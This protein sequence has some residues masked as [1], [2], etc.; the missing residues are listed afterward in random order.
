MTTSQILLILLAGL[1]YYNSTNTYEYAKYI[2]EADVLPIE[3][4]SS[5]A[6]RALAPQASLMTTDNIK[7]IL[8]ASYKLKNAM[9]EIGTIRLGEGENTAGS[10]ALFDILESVEPH[11]DKSASERVHTMRHSVNRIHDTKKNIERF[12][13]MQERMKASND[14]A[15]KADILLDVLAPIVGFDQINTLRGMTSMLSSLND[16][17][18]KLPEFSAAEEEKS[19]A[20]AD[21]EMGFTDFGATEES[22]SRDEKEQKK[23][24]AEIIEMFD[25]NKKDL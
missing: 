10:L 23:Q 15:D 14:S 5:V 25:K 8:S 17:P 2:Q 19:D 7:Q 12:G 16:S 21:D 20:K 6:P 22:P 9:S 24:L 3:A 11:L 18:L 4:S 1:Y 13:R